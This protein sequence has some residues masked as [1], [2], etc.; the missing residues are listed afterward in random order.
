M[1]LTISLEFGPN[2]SAEDQDVFD[3]A[4]ARWAQ[5][6]PVDLPPVRVDGAV[7]AG[8]AISADVTDIDGP[9]MILGQAGP[10]L[11]RPDTLL[12][13]RGVMEFDGGDLQ[14]LRANGTLDD[15]IIHEMG[16]VLGFGTLWML[17]GLVDRS[18]P[19]DPVFTGGRSLSVYRN[20]RGRD[21]LEGVPLA[22]TGGSGT[23][24]AHWRESLFTNELMTGFINQGTN[25]LSALT[26]ASM[27]DLG[28]GVDA[29]TADDFTI[30][31]MLG[32][33]F[34]RFARRN[35]ACCATRPAVS[36]LDVPPEPPATPV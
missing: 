1:A 12:P 24:A 34:A 29:G 28:Y 22:N 19:G 17:N 16:H 8:V 26:I 10:T 6:I 18:R 25:P 13:V 15:V 36:V 7:Q 32:R 9:G 33:F 3:R 31:G 2:I 11:V 14:A 30:A 5:I 20:L 27:A 4:A 21:D 35:P 23:F